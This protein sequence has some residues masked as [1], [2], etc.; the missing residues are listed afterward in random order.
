MGKKAFFCVIG[1]GRSGFSAAKLLLKKGVHVKVTDYKDTPY[2][3]RKASYLRR[4][5]AEVELGGHSDKFYRGAAIYILSPGVSKDNPVVQYT[6]EE[7]LPLISEIELAWMFC[8]ARIVAIT[9]TNGK[10]SVSTFTYR[11]LKRAGASAFLAGNIGVPFSEVVL[12]LNSDDILVLEVSSF[13][14]EDIVYFHP[15]ISVLLNISPDHMDRYIRFEDYILAKFNI[16]KNQTEEDFAIL[17][18][19]QDEIRQRIKFIKAKI[20]DVSRYK[21]LNLDLNRKFVFSIGE[22]LGLDSNFLLKEI[23]KLKGLRHRFED[24]GTVDGVRFINDS[25]ATNP[26]ATKWALRRLDSEVILIAGGRDKNM[27]F[28]LVREEVSEKV[29]ALVLIGE[30]KEK[31]L[32]SLGGFVEDVRFADDLKEA[33][34]ISFELA[35]PGDTVLLSPMC[36]SFDMFRDYKERGNEFREI[37]RDLAKCVG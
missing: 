31:I 36:A 29:K 21:D 28:S 2:L 27:D 35:S 20:I 32:M 22:I 12:D 13:Q 25:K 37:V 11:I 24:L 15:F 23:P 34:E 30:S 6:K 16:F 18:L 26:H 9:G 10:S 19:S 3:R 7:N 5:G 8:P 14:L 17:D 1:L 33:V 4:L